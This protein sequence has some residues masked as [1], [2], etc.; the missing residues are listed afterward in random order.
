M[1]D[2]I[3]ELKCI[4]KFGYTS[5]HIEY[6]LAELE[7]RMRLVEEHLDKI[8]PIIGAGFAKLEGLT[9]TLSSKFQDRDKFI[10]AVEKNT[11]AV[12]KKSKQIKIE[13]N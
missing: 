5:S 11:E 8:N 10:A 2:K 7:E 9:G 4:E 1:D 3:F 12:I 13:A 6:L